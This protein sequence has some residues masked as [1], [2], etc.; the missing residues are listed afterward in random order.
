MDNLKINLE[1]S[2]KK[3]FV[4]R[5]MFVYTSVITPDVGKG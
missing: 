1:K 4:N 5:I 3:I 2:G